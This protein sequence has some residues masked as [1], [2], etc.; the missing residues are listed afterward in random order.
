MLH[1]S[2]IGWAKHKDNVKARRGKEWKK[3]FVGEHV[4][5]TLAEASQDVC[6]FRVQLRP[7]VLMS[8]LFLLTNQ[9]TQLTNLDQNQTENCLHPPRDELWV[10]SGR[11]HYGQQIKV[12]PNGITSLG[13]QHPQECHSI[14]INFPTKTQGWQVFFSSGSKSK[15]PFL[16]CCLGT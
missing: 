3:S 10:S 15:I 7:I 6:E 9:E 5:N 8:R 2:L 13:R 4:G 1:I 16:S 12:Q 14:F 11:W